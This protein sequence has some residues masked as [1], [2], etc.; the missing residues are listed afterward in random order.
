MN[1]LSARLSTIDKLIRVGVYLAEKDGTARA[2]MNHFEVIIP[3]KCKAPVKVEPG[4]GR[5][6]LVLLVSGPCAMYEYD[7]DEERVLTEKPLDP[8]I[9]YIVSKADK[10]AVVAR[11]GKPYEFKVVSETDVWVYGSFTVMYLDF[12]EKYADEVERLVT[13]LL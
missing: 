5:A 2:T 12:D 1:Y 8:F 6:F 9:V 11:K 10:P 4:K 3:P 13:Y 7:P